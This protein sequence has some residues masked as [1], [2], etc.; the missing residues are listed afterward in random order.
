MLFK[1]WENGVLHVLIY[2]QS[3]FSVDND[4]ISNDLVAHTIPSVVTEEEN[5]MLLRLPM[6]DEIKTVVF[7]LNGDGA[8][9]PDGFRGHFY[10]TFWD[11]V[12]TKCCSVGARVFHHR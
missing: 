5:Q 8:P 9:G 1:S 2:F 6:C 7:D 10:Q 4:C 11:I 12:G 3:I